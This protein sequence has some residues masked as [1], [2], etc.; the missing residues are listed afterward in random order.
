MVDSGAVA[1]DVCMKGR[2]KHAYQLDQSF[3]N[4]TALACIIII[5]KKLCAQALLYYVCIQ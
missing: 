3:Y 2:K 1:V 5:E 4:Y